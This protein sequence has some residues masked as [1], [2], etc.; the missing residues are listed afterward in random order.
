MG[1][2][3][4]LLDAAA[5]LLAAKPS[6]EATARRAIS[7]GYYAL[8]HL[9]IEETC[10]LW[11]LP[12]QRPRLSRQFDHKRMRDASAEFSRQYLRSSTPAERTLGT[13]AASFVRAQQSR[14]KADYDLTSTI[15]LVDASWEV[16]SIENTFADWQQIRNERVAQDYLYSLLFKDR[17]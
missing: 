12:S 9:L 6:T 4:D 7:T 15:S 11:N 3:Q 17:S 14:H 8:F 13:I 16:Y 5:G 2:P 10:S 1:Y